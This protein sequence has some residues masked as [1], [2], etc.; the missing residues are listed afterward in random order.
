T[1][2]SSTWNEGF[3]DSIKLVRT[4]GEIMALEQDPLSVVKVLNDR[5]PYPSIIVPLDMRDVVVAL[6]KEQ[7]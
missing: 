7:S 1:Y 4:D 3:A 5:K 6:M 2:T